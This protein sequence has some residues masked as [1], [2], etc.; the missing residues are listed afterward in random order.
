MGRLL[1]L[2]GFILILA[3]C[4]GGS[5]SSRTEAKSYILRY[6]YEKGQAHRY[7]VSGN[8][9]MDL[10]RAEGVEPELKKE[11]NKASFS[12]FVTFDALEAKA[13]IYK[14]RVRFSDMKLTEAT[15]G[16]KAL[17]PMLVSQMEQEDVVNIDELGKSLDPAT[18]SD[19]PSG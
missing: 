2:S 14:L 16:L 4:D 1:V 10:A 6:K 15:G 8:F 18:A 19:N 11:L 3:G 13:G 9:E 12:G 7:A 5:V 17:G